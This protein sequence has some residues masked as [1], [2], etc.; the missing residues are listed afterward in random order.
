[1]GMDPSVAAKQMASLTAVGVARVAKVAPERIPAY[2]Q[3]PHSGGAPLYLPPTNDHMGHDNPGANPFGALSAYPTFQAPN[4]ISISQQQQ[5]Q[6][7]LSN[8]GNSFMGDSNMA[9]PNPPP[10]ST[11]KQRQRA[12]LTGLSGVM[13]AKGTPLPPALTGVPDSRYDPLTSPWKAL[14]LS[15]ELGAFRVA[16]KD[17]DLFKLWGTVFQAGGHAKVCTR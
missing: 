13:N 9:G 12:F 11:L 14:E 4:S 8:P 2:P 3:A 6:Q 17:V 16:G 7:Q 5:Q 1:M 10:A 15:T